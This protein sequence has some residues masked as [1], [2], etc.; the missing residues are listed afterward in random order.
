MWDYSQSAP[1]ESPRGAG[2]QG[3]AVDN[4]DSEE[5]KVKRPGKRHHPTTRGGL[6]SFSALETQIQNFTL[7]TG[8]FLPWC[9]CQPVSQNHCYTEAHQSVPSTCDLLSLLIF[10]ADT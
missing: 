9:L 3:S 4:E 1:G 7:P 5:A 8:G 2:N 10:L 6:I